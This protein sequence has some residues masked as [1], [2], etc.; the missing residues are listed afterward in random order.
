MAWGRSIQRDCKAA[1]VS[2]ANWE[3]EGGCGC[4][5]EG[6]CVQMRARVHPGD[7]GCADAGVG[8]PRGCGLR[9]HPGDVGYGCVD[10]GVCAEPR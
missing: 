3:D 2:V 5:D 10:E 4:V 6:A 8:A 7:A 1:V 9:V